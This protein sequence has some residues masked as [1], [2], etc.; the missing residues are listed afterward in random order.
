MLI[1][2]Q[3]SWYAVK[4]SRM[5]ISLLITKLSG[6]EELISGHKYIMLGLKGLCALTNG[7]NSALLQIERRKRVKID[8]CMKIITKTVEALE[9]DEITK[10]EFETIV[11]LES[12]D[13]KNQF[14]LK[15]S[16]HGSIS[17]TRLARKCVSS[18]KQLNTLGE[19][20]L[21]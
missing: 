9:D 18:V 6:A 12:E 13:D 21:Y 5:I 4:F 20:Y 3:Q 17:W 14:I 15:E 16:I 1:R 8:L 7:V 10:E 19:Y 2:N 11:K